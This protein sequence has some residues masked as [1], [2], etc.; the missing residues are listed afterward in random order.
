VGT[1]TSRR[2]HPLDRRSRLRPLGAAAVGLLLVACTGVTPGASE[3]ASQPASPSA[4]VAPTE[5]AEPVT[6]TAWFPPMFQDIKGYDDQSKEVGDFWQYLVDT[7]MEENPHV[8]IELTRLAWDDMD[9]KISV[10]CSADTQPDITFDF[11]AR[12][13]KFFKL[14]CLEAVDGVYTAQEAEDFWSGMWAYSFDP[15]GGEQYMIPAVSHQGGYLGIVEDFW[16]DAGQLALIPEVNGSWTLD[17]FEA[18]V[19]AIKDTLPEGSYP[20]CIEMAN[21]HGMEQMNIVKANRGFVFSDDDQEIAGDDRKARYAE[22]LER[23]L[24]WYKDGWFAPAPQALLNGECAP[25]Y[26]EKKIAVFTSPRED[27]VKAGLEA[28][29]PGPF[30]VRYVAYPTYPGEKSLLTV[31]STGW[32][33]GTQTDENK[34]AEVHKLLRWLNSTEN[35]DLYKTSTYAVGF[36]WGRFSVSPE[37]VAGAGPGSLIEALLTVADDPDWESSSFGQGFFNAA[38]S[39]TRYC[40]FPEWQAAFNENKTPQQATDDYWTCAERALENAPQ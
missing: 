16:A 38:F 27:L 20:M 5:A 3:P 39:E 29:A 10:A 31:A 6:I 36:L 12:P 40:E 13:Y 21:E 37:G 26:Q 25:I 32:A 8:T 9:P 35:M 28:G 2:K 4:T 11:G 34:R 33:V 17:E 24:G 22:M 7:Y 18:A 30:K 19:N 1:V 15:V 14:G 23:M